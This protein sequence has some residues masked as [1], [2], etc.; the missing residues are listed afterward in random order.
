M[1]ITSYF[2]AAMKAGASDLHLIAGEQPY[3]RVYGNLKKLDEAAPL[4]D[5]V[6]LTKAIYM[7]LTK[8]QTAEFEELW[9]LDFAYEYDGMRFRVNLHRQ[10]GQIGLAAR[11]V[12]K[13]IP[14]AADISLEE[15]IYN[16]THL[17][18]GLVLVTGPTSSGKSTT[19][20]SMINVINQE[21]AAHIVT[22]EDPIEYLY[23]R[24]Q[25]SIIEQR[26]VG[27]DTQSFYA[28]LKYVL[29]QDP[30]VILIGEMRDPETIAAA[31]TAAETGHLVFSTLHTNSAAETVERIVDSFDTH[32]QRQ[33][34]TQLASTLKAVITQ[35][36]LPTVDGKLVVAREIMIVNPA[37]ANLIRQNKVE[38][39]PSAIQT[40]KSQGMVTL[41][42]A[43]K[44]LAKQGLIDDQVAKNRSRPATSKLT[45]Y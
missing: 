32:R 3:L 10:L 30:N 43:I 45:Y 7:I 4:L 41:D 37:V 40:G 23:P 6:E 22:F 11:L 29:R 14:S 38:Q 20:A 31:L 18:Q 28:G 39:I 44:N 8:E 24:D 42:A 36:L 17:N 21:R 9:E 34:L 2:D 35:Q 16:L 5:S 27:R 15:P 33:I 25:K 1:N 26:E 19:L 13:Q 12:P